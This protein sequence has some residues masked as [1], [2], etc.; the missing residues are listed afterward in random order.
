MEFYS[1]LGAWC[2]CAYSC[3]P[4]FFSSSP[5]FPPRFSLA[6]NW[7]SSDYTLAV[8]LTL[9]LVGM[10]VSVC[11][12]ASLQFHAELWQLM[13]MIDMSERTARRSSGMRWLTLVSQLHE[14]SVGST[15]FSGRSYSSL[16]NQTRTLSWISRVAG[17]NVFQPLQSDTDA[18]ST[19]RVRCSYFSLVARGQTESGTPCSIGSWTR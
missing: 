10:S 2:C 4:C 6:F 18:R 19:K 7:H 13:M 15:V 8:V 1:G 5:S 16:C 14:E 3:T 12:D 11:R 17:E 9:V